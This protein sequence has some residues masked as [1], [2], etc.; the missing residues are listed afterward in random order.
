MLRKK[1]SLSTFMENRK[2]KGTVPILINFYEVEIGAVPFDHYG[3]QKKKGTVPLN[4]RETIP[5][6][7]LTRKIRLKNI[8][9]KN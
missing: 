6:R 4:P 3:K 7:M 9:I 1:Q 5:F 8:P 2:E